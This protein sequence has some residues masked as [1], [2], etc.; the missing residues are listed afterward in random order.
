MDAAKQCHF[1]QHK[2]HVYCPGIEPDLR[3]Q[4]PTELGHR[5]D[6]RDV[7]AEVLHAPLTEY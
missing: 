7:L 3:D 5:R 1:V 4:K 6:P 2:Y